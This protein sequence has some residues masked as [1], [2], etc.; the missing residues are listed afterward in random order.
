MQCELYFY[1]TCPFCQMVLS[2]IKALNLDE[3]IIL[4]DTI[5]D[6]KNAVFHRETTGRNTVPCLYIDGKPLFESSD[7]CR[8]LEENQ[9][10]L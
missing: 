8:W 7:I 5:K 4:K 10:N 3:K 2:K 1:Q 6:P 9:N